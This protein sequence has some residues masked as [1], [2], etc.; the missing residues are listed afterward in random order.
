MMISKTR[1]KSDNQREQRRTQGINALGADTSGCWGSK[2][3]RTRS[4]TVG[5]LP[6]EFTRLRVP[7]ARGART[8]F[9]A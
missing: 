9:F 5:L 7:G 3:W 4:Q 6:T 2:I 8:Q 1:E